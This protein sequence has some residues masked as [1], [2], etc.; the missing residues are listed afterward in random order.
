MPRFVVFRA[1]L[2]IFQRFFGVKGGKKALKILKF[3]KNKK[4]IFL[5]F[6]ISNFKGPFYLLLPQKTLKN[7]QKSPKNNKI[8]HSLQR[9]VFKIIG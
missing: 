3:E 5:F 4:I 7:G 9:S 1:F 8:G 2:A 6:R